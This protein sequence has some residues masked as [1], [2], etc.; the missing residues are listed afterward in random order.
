MKEHRKVSMGFKKYSIY[1]VGVTNVR[2][3]F[4]KKYDHN[5]QYTPIRK[6]FMKKS[7]FNVK[8]AEVGK[9]LL[10][11]PGVQRKNQNRNEIQLGYVKE[12]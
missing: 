1:P 7:I 12:V 2:L 6:I 11:T 4:S 5:T 10:R 3:C 8:S 9:E